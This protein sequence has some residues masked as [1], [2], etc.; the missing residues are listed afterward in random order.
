MSNYTIFLEVSIGE[1]V[2]KLSILKIKQE[3]ITD[4]SKINYINIEA[5]I[6]ERSLLGLKITDFFN[7]LIEVNKMLWDINDIRKN[8][9][10]T[11]E[12]DNDFLS[13]SILE[14][15]LNDKRFSIKDRINKSFDCRVQEQKSYK[16][17]LLK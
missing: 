8:K 5:E 7:E 4:Q 15:K 17:N 9:I 10:E 11:Q 12:Y 6:L 2:D 1:A 14:S 16:N 13:L 3:K